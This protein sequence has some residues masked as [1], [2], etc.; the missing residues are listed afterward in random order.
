MLLTFQEFTA[1]G[2]PQGGTIP[3]DLRDFVE[4]VSAK[5]RPALALFRRS[6]VNTTFVNSK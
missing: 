6:R 1:G 4:N 3:E 2:R 5:D